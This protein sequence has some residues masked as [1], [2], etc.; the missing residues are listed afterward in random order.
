LSVREDL[1][2]EGGRCEDDDEN[3]DDYEDNCTGD[4]HREAIE[5]LR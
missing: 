4:A 5:E 1:L 2:L 3:D